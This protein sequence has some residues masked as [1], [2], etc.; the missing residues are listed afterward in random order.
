MPDDAITLTAAGTVESVHAAV[1]RAWELAKPLVQVRGPERTDSDGEI[2]ARRWVVSI[3]EV[4]DDRSIAQNRFYFGSVL[5]QIAAQAPGGW[6]KDAFHELF[7]REVLGYEIIKVKVAGRK[8]MTT[9]RRLRSTA[10]LSVKQFSTFIDEVMALA[11]TTLGVE[12]DLD[13]VEREAVRWTPKRRKAS[14]A[15]QEN[16]AT[17]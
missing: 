12:F 14:T 7:K 17:I 11:A 1:R 3:G 13:P 2:H 8:R 4:E 9:I 6:S 10:K 5:S 16:E 15:T